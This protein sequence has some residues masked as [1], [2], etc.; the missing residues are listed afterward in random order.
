[1]TGASY[2]LFGLLALATAYVIYRILPILRFRGTMLVTCPENRKP[3][4]VKIAVGRAAAESL[5]GRPHVELGDCS[6]WPERRDCGQDCLCEIEADPV[7]H[8]VW[9]VATRWYEGKECVYCHK[10]IEPLSHLDQRPALV[11]AERKTVEWDDLPPEKLPEALAG[12]L[13]VCWNCHVA[14]TLIRE[15]PDLVTFRKWERSGP[16]GEYTPKNLH[17]KSTTSKL[18]N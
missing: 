7:G 1:M 11:D 18:L 17:E 14:E 8:R 5:V 12:C 13:P 10:P 2:L 9:S 6:R 4:A 3:A 16:I 15:H